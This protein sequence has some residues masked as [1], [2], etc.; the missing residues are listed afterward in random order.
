MINQVSQYLTS[1][2]LSEEFTLRRKFTRAGSKEKN[3]RDLNLEGVLQR[4]RIIQQRLPKNESRYVERLIRGHRIFGGTADSI[5]QTATN[6]FHLGIEAQP[7]FRGFAAWLHDNLKEEGFDPKQDRLEFQGR[8]SLLPGVFFRRESGITPAF[9]PIS[10][11]TLLPTTFDPSPFAVLEGGLKVQPEAVSRV[12]D[13]RRETFKGIRDLYYIDFGFQGTL[14]RYE[15]LLLSYTKDCPKPRKIFLYLVAATKIHP[16]IERSELVSPFP[17]DTTLVSEIYR[18][19]HEE[20]AAIDS[21]VCNQG[22]SYELTLRNLSSGV[23]PYIVDN[24]FCPFNLFMILQ[25]LSASIK[26]VHPLQIGKKAERIQ[27]KSLVPEDLYSIAARYGFFRGAISK[28]AHLTRIEDVHHQAF[29]FLCRFSKIAQEVP[30]RTIID[31]I[32]QRPNDELLAA[33]RAGFPMNNKL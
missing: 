8:D 20:L 26:S 28:V 4:H 15:Q 33:V 3:I 17:K 10:R 30:F 27:R 7:F 5:L 21:D 18:K 23:V 9:A 29:D 22:Y 25:E 31:D 13:Y 6:F 32:Y 24:C 19:K 1:F 2:G 16:L 14:P 12:I 11:V